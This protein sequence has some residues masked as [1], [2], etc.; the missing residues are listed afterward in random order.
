MRQIFACPMIVAAR[1]Y[2]GD[3]RRR[4][5]A[6]GGSSRV[7][8]RG[9]RRY[10][11]GAL[12]RSARRT[13]VRVGLVA[14]FERGEELTACRA[15]RRRERCAFAARPHEAFEPRIAL[16]HTPASRGRA[17][18]RWSLRARRARRSYVRCARRVGRRRG[19]DR[20]VGGARI[21]RDPIGRD[22]IG[23]ARVD[24]DRSKT[25]VALCFVD[26]IRGAAGTHTFVATRDD[27]HERGGGSS[28]HERLF[29][30]PPTGGNVSSTV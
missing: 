4:I 3:T 17:R 10:R 20:S 16:P 27:E 15:T 25:L 8:A 29:H 23:D 24:H 12:R 13:T 7:T 6:S 1:T 18:S 9:V 30:D 21:G 22:H 5:G 2:L 26:G 11:M 28:N 19:V 14:L